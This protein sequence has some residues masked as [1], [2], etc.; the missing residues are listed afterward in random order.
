MILFVPFNSKSTRRV[1][2]VFLLFV[3]GHLAVCAQR[4]LQPLDR[5]VV[6]VYRSGGRSV[7]S[8]GGTGYLVSWRKLAQEPEGTTY[9]VYCRPA[10]ASEFT[11]MNATPSKVTNYKPASLTPNA[12]Y[13]VTAI[14]PGGVEGVMSKP[15]LYKTQPWPNVWLNINFDNTVLP[16]NDYR[17]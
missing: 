11:K 4:L 8:S 10:G 9:N 7:T 13:A 15:F 1:A 2:V 12:E 5:G 17:T 6:A 3:L 14:T 16:R